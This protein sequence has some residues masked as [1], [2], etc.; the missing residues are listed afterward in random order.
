MAAQAAWAIES[1]ATNHSASFEIDD[2]MP[3]KTALDNTV[4]HDGELRGSGL[5]RIVGS[6]AAL[7]RVLGM[8][9]VVAPTDAT[10][11]ING[12]TG[13]GKE[14]IAEA[15]HMCSDRSNGPFVKVNCGAIPAGLLESELFGH[16]R[17]AYTGAVTRSVGRF[18]RAHRGTLFLDEIGD[19]PLEL[20]PKILRV[21]QERQFE[22]LGGA[23]TIH[24]DVRVICATH[25]NLVEMIEDR[26][27]RA[28]LFYRLSVFPIELPPLRERPEDIR[29]LVQHFAIDYGARTRKSITGISEEFMRA[30]SRHTWPGNIR[31]LQNFIER[32]VILSKGPVLNGPLSDL[33]YPAGTSAPVTLEEAERSHILRMLQ[34]TDG[35]VGGPNGAAARLGLRRTTLISKIRRLGINRGRI[36]TSPGAVAKGA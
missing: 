22:R 34:Q 24:T 23:A 33:T 32:S 25:R 2:T 6:S 5:P 13:T 30:L 7:R 19:L 3:R 15:I 31:E 12:E 14:L 10:V 20:Q 4:L 17:G 8:V 9:Q 35:V 36:L 11:L 21:M 29:L 27:F 26:D 1:P 28:D 16:E 18:E